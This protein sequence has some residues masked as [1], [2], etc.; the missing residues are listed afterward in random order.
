[1]LL[2]REARQG[3]ASQVIPTRSTSF[4]RI[5]LAI[6]QLHQGVQ[7][8]LDVQAWSFWPTEQ[9]HT[10]FLTR[11]M[12]DLSLPVNLEAVS[13]CLAAQRALFERLTADMNTRWG[14]DEYDVQLYHDHA[15][16]VIAIRT[17]REVPP[18]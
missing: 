6:E 18:E 2:T 16:I 15:T 3:K 13:G 9:R 12:V 14:L 17:A 11:H 7:C 8:I 1:M 10:G 5:A 4:C